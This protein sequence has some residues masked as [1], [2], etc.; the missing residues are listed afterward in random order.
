MQ[1]GNNVIYDEKTGNK[2]QDD[3][4]WVLNLEPT[5]IP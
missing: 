3:T 2:K 1:Q 4:T 5:E